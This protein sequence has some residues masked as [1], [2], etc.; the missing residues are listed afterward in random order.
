[1]RGEPEVLDC[2]SDSRAATLLQGQMPGRSSRRCKICPPHADVQLRAQAAP[3]QARDRAAGELEAWGGARSRQHSG[4][5]RAI[6]SQGSGRD[7]CGA[8]NPLIRW[9]N[10]EY[11]QPVRSEYVGLC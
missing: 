1:M 8:G 4:R 9:A 2:S 6:V 5:R 7:K 10:V 11:R 3:A